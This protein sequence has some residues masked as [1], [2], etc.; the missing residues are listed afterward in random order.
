MFMATSL[1]VRRA[2]VKRE[3][4]NVVAFFLG[5]LAG[6]RIGKPLIINNFREA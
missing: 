3:R 5:I 2:V 4:K 1:I 6:Q